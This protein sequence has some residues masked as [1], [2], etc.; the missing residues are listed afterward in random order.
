MFILTVVVAIVFVSEGFIKTVLSFQMRPL[1]GSGWLLFNG[2]VS[3]VFGVMLWAQLPSSALWALGT[4]AGI[5]IMISGWTLVM[6]PIAL[7][8][9]LQRQSS[10]GQPI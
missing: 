6:I 1:A 2:I 4:L 5:S 3:F 8:K 7:G 9:M 10:V